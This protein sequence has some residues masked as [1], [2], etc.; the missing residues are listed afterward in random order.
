VTLIYL[1]HRRISIILLLSAQHDFL[2]GLLD[3]SSKPCSKYIRTFAGIVRISAIT[4]PK[5][6]H[7]PT[8]LLTIDTWLKPNNISE[9]SAKQIYY[10]HKVN[11]MTAAVISSRETR[12]LGQ[13][14]Y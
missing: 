14:A 11:N 5:Y 9:K 2:D 1:V 10:F 4:L 12:T 13:L 8:L 7:H 6:P 3:I